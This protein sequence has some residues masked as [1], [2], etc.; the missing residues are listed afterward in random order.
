MKKKILIS[1]AH[2][3]LGSSIVKFFQYSQE[4]EIFSV[5]KKIYP[6]NKYIKNLLPDDLFLQTIKFYA[7]FHC[8]AEV[9]VNLCEDQKKYA[10]ESNVDFTVKLFSKILSDNY[11][12]ISTDSVYDGLIGNYKE[13]DPTN[14]VNYYATT[15]LIGELEVKKLY[16]NYYIIRTNIFGI[17]SNNKNSLFEWAYKNLRNK[18]NITGFT[19]VYFNP[20]YV[21]HLT[22]ILF[23][24]LQTNINYG[25]Y[26]LGSSSYISKYDFLKLISQNF[27][28]N[29]KLITPMLFNNNDNLAKR[30]L[31]TT[32][33]C[34]KLLRTSIKIDNSINKSF[35]MLI[36][37]LNK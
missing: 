14:P 18:N 25:I 15:K 26:N 8:A 3:M 1:G 32:L 6:D 19:N 7:F 5:S 12:Y 28:F 36:S 17:S 24:I 30:P 4:Y 23:N 35:T 31:N 37:D 29:D 21:S 11:F 27:N 2:G 34:T 9:N 16:S 33:N 20:L 13:I 10:Y 22:E